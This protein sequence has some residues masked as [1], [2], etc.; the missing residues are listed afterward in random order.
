[1][2]SDREMAARADPQLAQH[3]L[4]GYSRG[5]VEVKGYHG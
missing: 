1:M 5:C 2:H 4:E 3:F